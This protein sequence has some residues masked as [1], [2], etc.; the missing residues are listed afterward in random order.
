MGI[1][2]QAFALR[3]LPEAQ[4]LLLSQPA[5]D[6]CARVNAGRRVALHVN[7]IAAMRVSRRMPE[8][9]KADIV[10]RRSRLEACDVASQ[11]RGFLVGP[12]DDCNGVPS[13]GRTDAMFNVSVPVGT[14]LAFRRY[15][16]NVRSIRN[17]RNRN[18][19]SIGFVC[20]LCQQISRPSWTLVMQ[21]G[22]ERIEPFARF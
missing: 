14:R 6:K 22:T 8:M 5:F 7:E 20:Q 1:G 2:R 21:H 11:L 19:R 18:A 17:R 13:N 10:K 15:G 4:Q 9:S 3:F 12:Q 16:I